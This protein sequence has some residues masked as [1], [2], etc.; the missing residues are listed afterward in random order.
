[1][2]KHRE[3]RGEPTSGLPLE[4]LISLVQVWRRHW[5][6]VG[7]IQRK[8][9]RA[10]RERLQDLNADVD[11]A[12]A[13]T[14]HL[15]ALEFPPETVSLLRTKFDDA[16]AVIESLADR[17][18]ARGT[19]G[20]AAANRALE[21]TR[22]AVNVRDIVTAG[23]SLEMHLQPI[24]ALHRPMRSPVGFEALA[25]FRTT[26]YEPPNIWLERAG[27]AGLQHELE[28]SCVRSALTLVDLLPASAYLA[29]N[30][31]PETLVSPEFARIVAEAPADRLVVEVTEHAI[32]REYESLVNVIGGLREHGLR[33]AVDDAGAGFA[34]FR[35]VLELSPE[36]IKLDTH[37]IRGIHQDRSR[38]ALVRSLVSFAADVG[39]TLI[40]EGIESGEDLM[41]LCDA[42]VPYG[43]GYLF[44]QPGPAPTV[45]R[46]RR[47]AA[48]APRAGASSVRSA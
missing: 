46:R 5:D 8:L 20:R 37:L 34:S 25:R 29:V 26:P 40:A 13:Q 6:E 11:T 14:R 23:E 36:I 16:L 10:A 15:F 21:A 32:V 48:R 12:L 17:P 2:V 3:D 28:L 9:P 41:T 38:E 44:A 27:Q 42:H 47:T 33:L 22:L 4:A 39:A 43:Q 19:S 7:A 24:V 35:H 18:A 1:M 30:V 45:L 31:S